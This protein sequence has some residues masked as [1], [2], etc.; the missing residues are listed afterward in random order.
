MVWFNGK[1][2]N[3]GYRKDLGSEKSLIS[4]SLKNTPNFNSARTFAWNAS[5]INFWD[6]K[7]EKIQVKVT[8]SSKIGKIFPLLRYIYSSF[9]VELY[10]C[11]LVSFM[12]RS[13]LEWKL[14]CNCCTLLERVTSLWLLKLININVMNSFQKRKPCNICKDGRIQHGYRWWTSG[15]Q[16]WENPRSYHP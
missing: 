15:T 16:W 3:L 1:D 12:W 6:T 11:R 5:G 4:L 9:F 13:D 8:C 14:D 10:T 7:S 2:W